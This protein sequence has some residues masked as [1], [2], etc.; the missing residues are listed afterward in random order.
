MTDI[1]RWCN[2][3]NKNHKFVFGINYTAGN[4]ARLYAFM[5]MSMSRDRREGLPDHHCYSPL[6]GG[7]LAASVL[8]FIV[9]WSYIGASI[10]FLLLSVSLWRFFN[11]RKT[12]YYYSEFLKLPQKIQ[13]K[14]TIASWAVT[15]ILWIY[16]I[17]LIAY[18]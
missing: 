18:F 13:R 5:I 2:R 9:S 7:I 14:W 3:N 17:I 10:V 12:R 15:T 1:K 6:Q 8:P 16:I 4:I 11:N